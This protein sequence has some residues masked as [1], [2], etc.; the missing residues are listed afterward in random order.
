MVVSV[1]FSGVSVSYSGIDGAGQRTERREL[2]KG[3]K[4]LSSPP[5]RH[6]G[7]LE[8][9]C[10]G[11]G[12]MRV[13]WHPRLSA[14]EALTSNLPVGSFKVQKSLEKGRN[15]V[16]GNPRESRSSTRNKQMNAGDVST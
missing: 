4:P 5:S 9:R 12:R 6:S 3:P 16:A 15:D 2:S 7:C 10:L 13:T 8:G 14:K 1:S 11:K